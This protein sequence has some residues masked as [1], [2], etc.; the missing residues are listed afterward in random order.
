M[1]TAAELNQHGKWSATSSRYTG[2][3]S[4]DLIEEQQ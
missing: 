3:P 4:A 2:N 1:N